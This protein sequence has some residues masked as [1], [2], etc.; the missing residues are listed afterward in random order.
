MI[1]SLENNQRASLRKEVDA[2][3][4]MGFIF[5]LT[6][7]LLWIAI[8]SPTGDELITALNQNDRIDIFKVQSNYSSIKFHF[9]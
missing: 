4:N 6:P 1:F 7:L 2:S 5:S 3:Q 8:E 9:E